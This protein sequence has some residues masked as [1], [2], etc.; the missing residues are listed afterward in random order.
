[1]DADGRPRSFYCQITGMVMK[2]ATP[3]PPPGLASCCCDP[4]FAP[5]FCFPSCLRS[6]FSAHSRTVPTAN[7]SR[8]AADPVMDPEGNSYERSAIEDWLR[9]NATSPVTRSPLTPQ[10]LAPNRALR[11]AIEEALG[12]H[13]PAA[14][15][16][17][18]PA[19]ASATDVAYDRAVGL[20]LSAMP[21]P[22]GPANELTVLATVQPPAGTQRTPSDVCCVVDVSGSMGA[23][24]TMQNADG[25][26]EAHGLSLL[27]VVKHAVT[28]VISVLEPTDRL[29]LV[30]YS[31]EARLVFDLIPM[32]EAGKARAKTELGGLQT[33]GQT[34]LWDGL[35]T[36]L[37]VLRRGCEDGSNRLSAVLLLTDGQ[38]NICPP[39][40]H[41]P[42]LKRYKDQNLRLSATISTFGFGYR[43][44]SELLRDIAAEGDGMYAFIPDSGFVGTAFVNA[45]SNLLVT[46]GKNA[47]LMLEPAPGVT[48]V[49]ASVPGGVAT[50]ETSWGAQLS[51]G[52]LQYGQHRS[53][54]ARFTI[55]TDLDQGIPYLTATLRCTLRHDP[56]PLTTTVDAIWTG[57]DAS[58]LATTEAL[59]QERLR[60]MMVDHISEA[61]AK[62]K[63]G[64]LAGAQAVIGRLAGEL[65]TAQP[66][67]ANLEAMLADVEGQV[68]EAISRQDWFSKWGGHYLPSLARAHHL[69]QCNNFKDPGIQQY[70]GELFKQLRDIA[71]ELFCKLPPPKPTAGGGGYS[72]AR[73]TAGHGGA[74]APA[75]A[76]PVDMSMYNNRSN[77]CFAGHCLVTMADGT[78]QPVSSI[79][80]G[81]W[82]LCGPGASDGLRDKPVQVR[83]VVK[84]HCAFGKC[85]LVEL[86]ADAMGLQTAAAAG[87]GTLHITAWHPVRVPVRAD[88]TKDDSETECKSERQWRFPSSI[89]PTVESDCDAIYSFVL[90]GG[91]TMVIAGVE[92]VTL[93]HNFTGEVVGHEYFGSSAVLD[94]LA[95]T[96]GWEAGLVELRPGP[97]LRHS[98]SSCGDSKSMVLDVGREMVGA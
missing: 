39:R 86:S 64:D 80:R 37:E 94:D 95:Q 87:P 34:N 14:V 5:S 92:C 84:T 33:G 70:G 20:T 93:G 48:L 60:L 65:R 19:P 66:R 73:P 15:G 4:S 25:G 97:L 82:V 72:Y 35:H 88:G 55:P 11:D 12:E 49:P 52:S 58:V 81:Q 61:V 29:S 26:L 75:P 13:T 96:H 38:P 98:H 3:P 46:M 41:L 40:G 63:G 91:H 44:D 85:Q 90:E 50:Q 30:A 2:G 32:D 71:D 16:A 21:T 59:T 83:C 18:A 43:L 76:R 6:L 9:R 74:R 78:V 62:A 28:T 23:E 77:P 57:W 56:E 67:S 8:V 22:G 68:S 69:Q 24:A 51:I 89:A 27:D 1:M 7:A 10:Q 45:A 53:F 17:P 31:S 47:E 36:G 79:A 42:M 54:T